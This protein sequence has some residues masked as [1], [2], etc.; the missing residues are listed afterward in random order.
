MFRFF[1]LLI[2]YSFSEAV[3]HKITTMPGWIFFTQWSY[4]VHCITSVQS[5]AGHTVGSQDVFAEERNG[6]IYVG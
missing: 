2:L 1:L 6:Q 4:I 3:I 5:S